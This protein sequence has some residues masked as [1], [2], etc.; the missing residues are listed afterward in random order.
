MLAAFEELPPLLAVD[1]EFPPTQCQSR[2]FG[3]VKPRSCG[4]SH[5]GQVAHLAAGT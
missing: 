1:L 5:V 4:A 3:T 2:S